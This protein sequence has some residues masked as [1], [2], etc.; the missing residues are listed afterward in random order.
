MSIPA[1]AREVFQKFGAHPDFLHG[2]ANWLLLHADEPD[3]SG[4][5]RMRQS[6]LETILD[7]AG[8]LEILKAEATRE[9]EMVYALQETLPLSERQCSPDSQAFVVNELRALHSSLALAVTPRGEPDTAAR[10]FA[11][12]ILVHILIPSLAASAE[13]GDLHFACVV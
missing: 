12:H 13:L 2:G 8:E 3:L 11:I 10:L 5:L 6:E 7:S 4:V 9:L 1:L